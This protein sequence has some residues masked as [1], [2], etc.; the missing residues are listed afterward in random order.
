MKVESYLDGL[1]EKFRA[2]A[3]DDKSRPAAK[4]LMV[5]V[6]LKTWFHRSKGGKLAAAKVDSIWHQA[7]NAEGETPAQTPAP[8]GAL[9]SQPSL[10][11]QQQQ[12]DYSPANTPLQLLSE[13]A[14]GGTPRPESRNQYSSNGWHQN[15]QQASQ[16]Q[17]QQPPVPQQVPFNFNDPN[18]TNQMPT[19][20]NMMY[21]PMG[22]IDPNLGIP[23][24]F[25]FSIGDGFE[26]AMG[27]TL[28]DG[29]FGKY[30]QD[31]VSVPLALGFKQKYTDQSLLSLGI[32]GRHDGQC[33]RH[34]QWL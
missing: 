29:D 17:Q 2:T 34:E 18:S 11:Q 30:F 20:Y 6:M 1:L 24:D 31:D 12:T 23:Q 33:W 28:G 22:N 7:P 4:F 19:G 21:G 9:I 16:P 3:A 15:N 8:S 10:L 5:L 13:V 14:T 32:L 27:I 25:D 26:Q